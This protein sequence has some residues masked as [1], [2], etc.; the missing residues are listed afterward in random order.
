MTSGQVKTT[1]PAGATLAQGKVD[2]YNIA[3]LLLSTIVLSV[4]IS[5]YVLCLA[6]LNL[7]NNDSDPLERAARLAAQDL[8]DINVVSANF[9]NVGIADFENSELGPGGLSAGA[10]G[11][12]RSYNTIASLL[13]TSL[14]LAKHYHLQAMGEQ[15]AADLKDLQGIKDEL[16]RKIVASIQTD[17]TGAIYEH[18]KRIL[19]NHVRGGASLQTLAV[20]LGT[21]HDRMQITTIPAEAEDAPAFSGSGKLRT[22]IPLTVPL[23][24]QIIYLHQQARDIAIVAPAQFV[25]DQKQAL[26]TTLLIEAQFAAPS[27]QHDASGRVITHKE[28][29]VIAGAD[30]KNQ[31]LTN[32]PQDGCLALDFPQGRPDRFDSLASILQFKDWQGRGDWLEAVQGAVPGTGHLA[33]PAVNQ[34][35]SMNGSDSL[36][37]ALYHWLRGQ[38][39]P[40]SPTGLASMLTSRWQ[41]PNTAAAQETNPAPSE[42]GERGAEELDQQVNSGLLKE[43]G[44]RLFALLYQNK[45]AEAGQKALYNCF[46]A[47][48]NKFPPSTLPLVIDRNGA[49]NLPGQKGFDRQLAIDL[50]SGIYNTNLAAQETLATAQL[51]QSSSMR[52]YRASKERLFLAQTELD[53]LTSR[54]KNESREDAR[55]ALSNEI[56]WRN[57]RIT[58]EINEQ[59]KQLRA[60]SLSQAALSNAAAVAGQSFECGSKLFQLTRVGINRL[61]QLQPINAALAPAAAHAFILGQRFIFTPLTQSLK[62]SDILDDAARAFD[63]T[64]KTPASSATVNSPWLSRNLKIFGQIKSMTDQADTTLLVEGRSLSDLKAETATSL[65]ATPLVVVFTPDLIAQPASISEAGQGTRSEPLYFKEYPFKGLSVAERQLLYYC[66]NGYQSASLPSGK[67]AWSILARDLVASRGLNNNHQRLGLP[68]A[69]T[70]TGWYKR[71]L[72]WSDSTGGKEALSAVSAQSNQA[73]QTGGGLAAEWQLR[74]PVMLLDESES[75]ILKGATLSDPESGQRVPQIPPVGP[76]LM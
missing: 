70:N 9:G 2:W 28:V 35:K 75:G 60:Y 43:S 17:G 20:K 51:M 58:Y 40:I 73:K 66:Q 71:A 53:S 23:S 19:S 45:P 64:A 11:E 1:G 13:R 42:P 34:L 61:A 33:P 36:S 30:Y 16:R 32:P 22:L 68:L 56:D 44:A 57:N 49:P 55:K 59:K 69:P 46:Q 31:P 3:V 8:L 38:S 14:F 72:N 27:R 67:V 63:A 76:D 18:I 15:A 65:K 62:E 24:N 10:A 47:T 26:P 39:R 4:I 12:V 21:S 7:K 25:P 50:L 41:I 37:I 48:A 5:S 52:A 29:C 54:L 74:S 6:W